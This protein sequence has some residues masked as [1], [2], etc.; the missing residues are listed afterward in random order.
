MFADTN[1]AEHMHVV[2]QVCEASRGAYC[3]ADV[4]LPF[5]TGLY[6]TVC[7]C[8]LACKARQAAWIIC[9]VQQQNIHATRFHKRMC[10][11]KTAPARADHNNLLIAALRGIGPCVADHTARE[12]S[13]GHA[14]RSSGGD[15]QVLENRE[16]LV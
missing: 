14:K 4:S 12:T 2:T 8:A 7:N 13:T 9:R 15:I 1:A 6:W 16:Q 10:R 5:D 11:T 3:R